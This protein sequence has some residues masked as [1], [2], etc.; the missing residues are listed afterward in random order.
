MKIGFESVTVGESRRIRIYAPFE[1]KDAI[2][3]V[4]GRWE[5]ARNYWTV[6]HTSVAI[7]MVS[8]S[9]SAFASEPVEFRYA[10]AACEETASQPSSVL[11]VT[12]VDFDDSVLPPWPHQKQGASMIGQM[13]GCMLA[14]DM[15][16]GKSKA[17]CDAVVRFG[18]SRTII[19]CPTSVI[20]VW[21]REFKKH[22]KP[23]HN[24]V[25]VALD[26]S[27]SVA[28]RAKVLLD[29][30]R[31]C[32]QTSRPIV[33]AINYEAVWREAM[34][35]IVCKIPWDLAVADESHRISSPSTRIGKFMTKKLGP[36]AKHR[37]ALTGTPMS[38]GPLDVFGQF[39]FCEPGLFGAG[40]TRFRSRYCIMGGFEGR[41]VV[42][43][44]NLP[45]L[46]ALMGTVSTRVKLNDVV[47]LPPFRDEEIVV[48]LCKDAAT[49]YCSLRDDFIAEFGQSSLVAVNAITK[50]LRLQ[51]ITS[52]YAMVVDDDSGD[53]EATNRD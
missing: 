8:D 17:V 43:H 45:E 22:V 40:F 30:C 7:K 34:S 42:D 21:S 28:D 4:G 44:Q 32:Y 13:S 29:K 19:C 47:D 24:L 2:K 33:A 6:A 48:E 10:D 46:T 50:L 3:A 52:G 11:D 20:R 23:S 51:Q 41:Q 1:V 25:F 35:K 15:G 36:H 26:G 18:F 31:E 37:V 16:S 39:L 49:A 14:W 27:L 38:N 5:R 53:E 12:E 9:I